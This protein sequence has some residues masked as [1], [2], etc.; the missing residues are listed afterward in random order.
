MVLG[1]ALD[2]RVCVC[3]STC[4]CARGDDLFHQALTTGLLGPE[5]RDGGRLVHS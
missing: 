3:V 4:V 2:F 5:G 1:P